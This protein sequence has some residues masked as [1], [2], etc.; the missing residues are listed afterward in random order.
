MSNLRFLWLTDY[1]APEV[2]FKPH[3]Y[4][5]QSKGIHELTVDAIDQCEIELRKDLYNV[6][7]TGGNTCF[8]GMKK[9]MQK[10][11]EK[12]APMDVVANVIA[13]YQGKQF[14]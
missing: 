10:E 12:L 1:R 4:D 13:P 6:V 7:L 2:M 11:L 3:L 8:P 14:A 9:R 5:F